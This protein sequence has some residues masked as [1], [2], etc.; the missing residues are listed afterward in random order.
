MVDVSHSMILYGEDRITPAKKIALAL[1]QLIQ[2]RYPKDT[3]DVVLFGDDAA[4][5]P[6]R[7]LLKIQAGPFHTNTQ[8]GL[9]ARAAH[10]RG[11]QGRQ[12]A[13]L[14]DHRRQALGDP[15]VRA[16]STRTRSASTR[17]S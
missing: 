15:R 10:P 16:G 17:R 1:T 14:H 7:D 2:T 9:A 11:A 6:L 13:D 8:A 4:Q 3:L 12:Q 5:V